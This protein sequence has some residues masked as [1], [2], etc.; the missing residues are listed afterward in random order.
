MSHSLANRFSDKVAVVTG[1]ASGIGEATAKRFIAE[2]ASVILSDQDDK[3]LHNLAASLPKDRAIPCIVD[4][5]RADQAAHSIETAI[6]HFGRLDILVN[7]AGTTTMGTV[8]DSSIEDWHRVAAVN[9]DGALFSAKAAL[10]HL[11][12]T[13][14]CIVNTAS[15]SGLGADWNTT[16]YNISKG[17]IVN[18]TRALAVAHGPDGVR[19]NAICPSVTHTGMTEDLLTQ[20]DYKATL[21]AATPLRQIGQPEHMAAGILFLASTDAAFIT[22]V[23]L[24]I[25][26][27]ITASNGQPPFKA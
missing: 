19:I 9:I 11:I 21:L 17:A 20:D 10:P 24:P 22:G 26:G 12:K 6:H 7:N 13:K 5:S 27:G 8:L 14:G 16:L 3:A 1:A 18:M 4:Q 15:V 25:D 2:G 23:N